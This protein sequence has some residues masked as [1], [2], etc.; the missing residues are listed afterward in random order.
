MKTKYLIAAILTALG[1]QSLVI[2]QTTL[3]GDHIIDGK[4]TVGSLEYNKEILGFSTVRIQGYYEGSPNDSYA[5]L[6]RSGLT[7]MDFEYASHIGFDKIYAGAY[8]NGGTLSL[9]IGTD[10]YPGANGMGIGT[11][12]YSGVGSVAVGSLLFSSSYS[13][14]VGQNIS[15]DE[16]YSIAFGLNNS[17]SADHVLVA[18]YGLTSNWQS[19]VIF[20]RYNDFTEQMND[21]WTESDPLF[22]L[23]NGTGDSNDPVE[24]RYHNAF[25]VRKNGAVEITGPV[26]MPRQGDIPMGEFG[27]AEP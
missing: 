5:L 27:E 1:W 18:G 14:A 7:M 12:I 10:S 21:N 8:A 25:V 19:C 4:L 9:A 13:V 17:G 23:G 24:T 2:A 15:L 22:I 16:P 11:E 6:S 20:G 26:T 3:S